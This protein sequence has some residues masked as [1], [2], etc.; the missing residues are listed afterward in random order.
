V[1]LIAITRRDRYSAPTPR[2]TRSSLR[3]IPSTSLPLSAGSGPV[4]RRTSLN[5]LVDI[6]R[7]KDRAKSLTTVIIIATIFVFITLITT[8]FVA[9]VCCKRNAVF[10]LQ[11]RRRHRR[12]SKSTYSPGSGSRDCEHCEMEQCLRGPSARCRAAH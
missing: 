12:D 9:V 2:L 6:V 4:R 3:S 7:T 5:R 11:P 10:A 1:C 8:F